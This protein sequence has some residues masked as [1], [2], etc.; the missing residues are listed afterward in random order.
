MQKLKFMTTLTI[1]LVL[2]YL[3]YIKFD[4]NWVD[5]FFIIGIL[6]FSILIIFLLNVKGKSGYF[7]GYQRARFG[8]AAPIEDNWPLLNPVTLAS[9][10]FCILSIVV[11]GVYYMA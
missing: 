2:V 7:T 10:L 4:F 11:S 5:S 6:T 1:E 8:F 3:L 9:G